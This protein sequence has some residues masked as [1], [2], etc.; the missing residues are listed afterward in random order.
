M[1]VRVLFER[2]FLLKALVYQNLNRKHGKPCVSQLGLASNLVSLRL[3]YQSN[4][5]LLIKY[6]IPQDKNCF[7]NLFWLCYS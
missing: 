3:I 1:D 5:S 7:N 6:N 4:Q 2:K